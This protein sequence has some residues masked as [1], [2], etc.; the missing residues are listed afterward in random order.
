MTIP[1]RAIRKPLVN[2]PTEERLFELLQRAMPLCLT[3]MRL[4]MAVVYIWFGALK[5]ASTSPVA[6]LVLA[7]YP[8]GQAPSW[9]VPLMGVV[10]VFIGLWFL[11]NRYMTYLFPLFLAHICSTFV[12]LVSAPSLA[13]QNN[14]PLA[15]TTTGE[16][17]IKNLVLIPAG[18]IVI[19]LSSRRRGGSVLEDA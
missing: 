6:T 16:F 11:S 18:T 7:A 17:V 19:L 13:Y 5:L 8:F 1:S 2:L 10:E 3:V 4:G 12:V 14:D 9:I 15:L